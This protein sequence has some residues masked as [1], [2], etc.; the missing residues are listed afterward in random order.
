M[1]AAEHGQTEAKNTRAII[2][3]RMMFDVEGDGVLQDIVAGID[4]KTKTLLWCDYAELFPFHIEG[5][6]P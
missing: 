2:F 1:P 4:V 3:V 5:I 6:T